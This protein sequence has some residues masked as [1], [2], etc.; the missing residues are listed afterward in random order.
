M[1]INLNT[2]VLNDRAIAHHL[3]PYNKN[4]VCLNNSLSFAFK[5]ILFLFRSDI[6]EEYGTEEIHLNTGDPRNFSIFHSQSSC[7]H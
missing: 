4:F 7:L 6:A 3:I 2:K 1:D 5:I